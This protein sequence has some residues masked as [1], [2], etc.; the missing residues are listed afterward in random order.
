MLFV[1]ALSIWKKEKNLRKLWKSPFF[2]YLHPGDVSKSLFLMVGSSW[3][4]TGLIKKH[5]SKTFALQ[6]SVSDPHTVESVSVMM[7]ISM[8]H[9]SFLSFFHIACFFTPRTICMLHTIINSTNA[10][11]YGR[12]RSIISIGVFFH[13]TLYF[14]HWAVANII[15]ISWWEKKIISVCSSISSC[16]CLAPLKGKGAN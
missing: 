4:H 8:Q 9:L 15:C 7:V 16:V 1:R 12:F 2:I 13:T 6:P 10:S 3:S 14:S 11:P 5:F